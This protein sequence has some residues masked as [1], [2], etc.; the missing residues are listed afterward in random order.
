VP[1]PLAADDHQLA[2][3]RE[4]AEAGAARVLEARPLAPPDLARARARA[5]EKP[6]ELVAMAQAAG[7][8]ARP[9]AAE[10]IVEECAALFGAGR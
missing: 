1:F 7:R 3:A 2:N 5:V 10:R 4:L 8:L 9:D 6:A